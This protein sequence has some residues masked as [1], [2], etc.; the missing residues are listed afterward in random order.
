MK[1]LP[2][3]KNARPITVGRW[4]RLNVVLLGLALI[5]SLS[6]PVST[7]SQKLND[8]FFRLRGPQPVSSHVALVLIDDATLARYGRW[9]WHRHLLAELVDA[10][11]RERPAAVGI[12]I[13]LSEPEDDQNDAELTRA[14]HAAPNVVLAAKI[15]GS[16]ESPLWVDPLPRFLEASR[17]AGHVQAITDFDGLCRSIPIQEPGLDGPRPAFSLKLAELLQPQLARLETPS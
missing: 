4:I 5:I 6:F 8:F 16:P 15:S 1:F 14:I 17:G 3:P 11:T 7:L 2:N 9:P 12:D 10:V 13:L